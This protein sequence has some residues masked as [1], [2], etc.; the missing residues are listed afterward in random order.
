MVD[1]RLDAMVNVNVQFSGQEVGTAKSC[2]EK[3]LAVTEHRGV[4]A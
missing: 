1:D 2:K 3:G 4:P